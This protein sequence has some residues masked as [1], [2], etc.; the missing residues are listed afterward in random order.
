[1]HDRFHV[2]ELLK[3]PGDTQYRGRDEE[4][5]VLTQARRSTDASQPTRWADGALYFGLAMMAGLAGGALAFLISRH[6]SDAHQSVNALIHGYLLELFVIP[7]ALL[8][9]LGRWLIPA[10]L[11]VRGMATPRLDRGSWVVLTAAAFL[12]ALG[13]RLGPVAIALSL[14]LWSVG[15][16]GMASGTIITVLNERHTTFRDLSLFIWSQLLASCTVILSAP[17]L[18]GALTRPLLHGF[19]S[20][21]LLAQLLG[22]FH[23]PLLGL[24]LVSAFGAAADNLWRRNRAAQPVIVALCAVIAVGGPLLWAHDLLTGGGSSAWL[25]IVTLAAPAIGVM[26]LWCRLLW[27]ESFAF[28]WPA[29][30]S[31]GALLLLSAGWG[32]RLMPAGDA[33]AHSAVLFGA[34]FAVFA[35]YYSWLQTTSRLH[36]PRWFGLLHFSLCAIG[37]VCSLWPLVTLNRVGEGAMGLSLLCVLPLSANMLAYRRYGH[38]R[39]TVR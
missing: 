8:G 16:V 38:G 20:T 12:L 39:R 6:G 25:E 17:L 3:K 10:R 33:A 22:A 36:I 1:M 21:Q 31:C 34:M 32:L 15:A 9:G 19:V 23:L 29:I 26:A 18:A 13:D 4:D 2:I 28:T 27:R 30:W 35:G 37:T 14:G 5:K 24:A 11:D 7:V